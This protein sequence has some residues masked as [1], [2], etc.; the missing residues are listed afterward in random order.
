M[1]RQNKRKR[2][3]GQAAKND[4][5]NKKKK[6]KENKGDKSR[7]YKRGV[8]A[9]VILIVDKGAEAAVRS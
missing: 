9:E 7:R 5:G 3:R 8:G 1:E 6:K 4:G 2:R